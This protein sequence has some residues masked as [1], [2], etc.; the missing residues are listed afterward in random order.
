MSDVKDE[1]RRRRFKRVRVNLMRSPMFMEVGPVMMLG[2]TE[3]CPDTPTA[4]TDGRNEKYGTAFIDKLED[5]Q[6][7][8]V[9]MHE[10]FVHKI[11]RHLTVYRALFD[12]DAR[13][14]NMAMDYW[15]NGKLVK[16]DPQQKFIAMP[17]DENGKQ[18]GLYDPKY[19]GL[20]VIEIFRLLKQEQRDG[21]GSRGGNDS[22][23]GESL[24]HHDWEAAGNMSDEEQDQLTSDIQQAVREG[25]MAAKRAG[26]GGK[27]DQLGLGELLTPK[28]DW[29]KQLREFVRATCRKPQTSTWA[30]P[31]RKY[32]A[33]DMVMPSLQG[34]SI[35]E[36][37]MAPDA[38]YSMLHASG[39]E[40]PPFAKC[41]SEIEGMARQLSVDKLHIIY[42]DGAVAGHETY[43]P[44][45]IKNWRSSTKPRGGGGTSPDCV[46]R[47]IKEKGIKADAVV[48]LTDGELSD[49]GRWSAPVLWAITHKS[50]TAPVGKTIHIQN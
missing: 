50:K 39:D 36:L 10:N 45:T 8:F 20:S 13:L 29:R 40:A 33:M 6:L 26:V 43:T 28:V 47:Y 5:K 16:I 3:L 17:R 34:K 25:Q 41:M 9:I 38:S 27:G 35:K 12:E 18:I 2:K 44:A 24:D 15:G 22:E 21:G 4:C 30:R 49:W 31:R 46:A 42:W 48:V 19:D 14:A 32:L 11:H 7:G 23:S 37:V 1:K